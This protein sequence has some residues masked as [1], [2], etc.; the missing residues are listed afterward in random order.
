[1]KECGL[2]I[3]NQRKDKTGYSTKDRDIELTSEYQN[4][5][6]SNS[7]AWIYFLNLAPSYKRSSIWWV[8][9][10]KKKETQLRRLK[11]LIESCQEGMRIPLIRK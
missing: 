9:T 1:M 11:I 6:R 2:V 7:K 3:Y 4:M 10:A 5:I 8:M